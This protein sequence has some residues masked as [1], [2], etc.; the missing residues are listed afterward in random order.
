MRIYYSSLLFY[1]RNFFCETFPK[2]GK[3]YRVDILPDAEPKSTPVRKIPYSSR[4]RDDA[5]KTNYK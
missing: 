1:L 5:G 4:I 3:S 2:V